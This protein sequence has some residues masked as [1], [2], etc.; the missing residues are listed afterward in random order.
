MLD[1]SLSFYLGGKTPL[2]DRMTWAGVIVVSSLLLRFTVAPVTSGIPFILCFPAVLAVFYVSGLRLGIAA[3]VLSAFTSLYFFTPPYSSLTFSPFA[4]IS[5]IIFV[6]STTIMGVV[7]NLFKAQLVSSRIAAAAFETQQGMIITDPQ[8]T[9]LQVN[10]AFTRTTGYSTEEVIGKNLRLLHSGRQD[11]A[12]YRTMWDSII[13]NGFWQ[14]EI[15]NKRK[16]GEIYPGWLAISAVKDDSGTVTHYV[17]AFSDISERKAAE[18]RIETLAFYDTLTGLPNRALLRDRLKHALIAATRRQR[19]AALLHIDLDHFKTINDTLGHDQGDLI[20]KEVV[21]RLRACARTSDT[22]A[23]IGGDEFILL[24]EGPN[25]DNQNMLNQARVIGDKVLVALRQPFELGESIHHTSA[26]IGITLM[27]SAE[28]HDVEE[29]LK[30]AELA[31]YQAK[32]AGRSTLRF[33]DPRMQAEVSARAS[34]ESRL[35]EALAKNQLVLHYQPQVDGAG[36]VAGSEALVRWLDPKRGMVS[37]G[38]FIPVAE[39]SG[40][41]LPLGQWVLESA[42]NQLVRWANE[43]VMATLTV[44]V[45]VS[46]RQ[47][48]QNTFVE[49]VLDTLKRTGA[50]PKR[51]KL[52]LTESML[53]DDITGVIAKMTALKA[54]GVSFSLDDFGTGYSSLVYLKRLPLDQL[55]IDQGFV[56]DILIDPNDA[57]IARTVI[58]LAES[59]GLAVIAEGVETEGQSDFLASA[60]CLAY[61][62]YLFSKPLPPEAFEVFV[63]RARLQLGD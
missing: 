18:Q 62:G 60:G 42:C 57:A 12:F 30:Q 23:R 34:L 8:A 17:G 3:A 45:N 54:Y 35:R 15:W 52:E 59:M 36:Q 25:Q 13:N 48:H 5:F 43:P 28:Q 58:A 49:Q 14:G 56:R 37:P 10:K 16:N 24:L 2:W 44:A 27:G 50:N 61:Q 29:P 1:R 31:M 39:Q 63:K 11:A 38:E 19:Q 6:G 55:K 4:L 53:V 21:M 22:L 26:S 40:L 20:I 7:I 47:F 32:V 33:F 41:I 51:L 9:I 46:A